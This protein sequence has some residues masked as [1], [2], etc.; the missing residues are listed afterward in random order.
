MKRENLTIPNALTVARIAGSGVLL[1]LA[2]A[3]HAGWF[4]GLFLA[5]MLTDWLD[6]KLAILL[7]QRTVLGAK[8]DSFGD[9]VSYVC[10]IIGVA[11][12]EPAFL[13]AHL[14]MIVAM[15]GSYGISVLASLIKFRRLP[16]Y[17]TRA[18]KTCWLL[19]AIGAVTLLARP[20]GVAD[21]HRLDR[22]RR[23]PAP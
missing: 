22:R 21:G 17:H 4:I 3:G 19:A 6:G 7:H 13:N 23:P 12:L 8:L 20:E 5:L 15:L 18:A 14:P 10:L 11:W 9:V 2:H 16:A 1:W